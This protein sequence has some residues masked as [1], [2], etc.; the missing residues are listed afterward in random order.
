MTKIM[1]HMNPDDLILVLDIH[2][3]DHPRWLDPKR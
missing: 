2:V 1:G 3:R